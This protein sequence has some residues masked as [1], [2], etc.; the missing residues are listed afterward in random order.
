MRVIYK[1]VRVIALGV[2]VRV[3]V[4]A[5]AGAALSEIF[6]L[7]LLSVQKMMIDYEDPDNR[8][9]G[10]FSSAVIQCCEK[11]LHLVHMPCNSYLCITYHLNN[12]SR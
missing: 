9:S 2:P 11:V 7:L 3:R 10:I 8:L 5:C 4:N 12:Y 6:K 1:A